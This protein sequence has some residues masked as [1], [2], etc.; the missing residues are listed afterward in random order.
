MDPVV[1]DI[2]HVWTTDQQDRLCRWIHQTLGIDVCSYKQ[3]YVHRRIQARLRKLRISDPEKYLALLEKDPAEPDH[4][5]N[6]LT[7]NVTQ[8]FRNPSTFAMLE[9][10]VYPELF[11]MADPGRPVRIWSLGCA[12]GEEPFSMS[13]QLAV[14]RAYHRRYRILGTDVSHA[15]LDRARKALY[16][17]DQLDSVPEKY[18]REIQAQEE[19][20]F[21]FSRTIKQAVRFRRQDILDLDQYPISDLVLC[22][23]VLIYFDRTRQAEILH[24]LAFC[25][26]D[27]GY[28]VLGRAETLAVEAR[29]LF[30]CVDSAERIYRKKRS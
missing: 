25:L 23:N 12:G 10:K 24:R 1:E 4:L 21:T 16:D 26:A 20:R 15:V 13:L 5:I 30:D 3:P 6:A 19:G 22:R 27:D 14:H 8:F 18:R 28:L 7:V 29:D 17:A 2:T 11:Q 9:E